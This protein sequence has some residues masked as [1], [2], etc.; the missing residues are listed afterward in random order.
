MKQIKRTLALLL[1]LM[2]VIAVLGGCGKQ[3]APVESASPVESAE[4]TEAADLSE[5]TPAPAREDGERFESVL[6][7]EG[8][9]EAIQYEHAVNQ[10]AGFE[11][12]YEYET[13][14]RQSEPDRERFVSIY[15]DPAAPESYVEVVCCS[16]DAE[17]AAAA[18]SEVLGKDY[19]L[20]QESLTLNNGV[21][22]IHIDASA[23]ADGSRTADVLRAVYVIPADDGCRIALLRYLPE[24]SDGFGKRLSGMVNTI[25]VTEAQGAGIPV[26]DY[27]SQW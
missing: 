27:L 6:F 8:M 10:T 11:M 3:A 2:L 12:D 14:Q 15:D 24:G 9:E 17:T 1:G 26:Q 7:I 16:D 5:A 21:A 4:P 18:I 23:V 19:A 13:F 20:Y 22:C 25:L